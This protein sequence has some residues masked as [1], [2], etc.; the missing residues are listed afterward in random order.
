MGSELPDKMAK[1]Q[2][3]LYSA[4]KPFSSW[5]FGSP[6]TRPGGKTIQVFASPGESVSPKIQLVG[7]GE[8]PLYAPFGLASAAQSAGAPERAN[9]EL[10]VTHPPLREYL[11]RL[12]NHIKN[13]AVEKCASWFQKSLSPEEIDLLHKPLLTPPTPNVP[14]ELLRVKA[15]ISGSHAVRVW[16]LRVGANAGWVYSPGSIQDISPGVE[17]WVNVSVN[18]LYFMARLFGCT[19]TATDVMIFPRAPQIFPF[20]T[21]MTV[22]EDKEE[23]SCAQEAVAS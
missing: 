15:T 22:T 6:V 1:Q 3:A 4:C 11:Q 18:S 8:P 14:M 10:S 12:D 9:L 19:L 2:P 5:T 20:L 17:C 16:K 13:V 7:D 21:A 23:E